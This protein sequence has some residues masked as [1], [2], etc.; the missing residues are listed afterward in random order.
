[1]RS[2]TQDL[3]ETDVRVRLRQETFTAMTA[4][5]GCTTDLARAELIGVTPRTLRRARA[6]VIGEGFM[7]KTVAALRRQS[8]TLAAHGL[9]PSLDALFEVV[10]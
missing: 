4:A 2:D 3:A 1:M 7:T 5:L 9:I 8:D 10:D 6:G